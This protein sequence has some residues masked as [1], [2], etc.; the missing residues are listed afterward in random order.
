MHIDSAES[1]LVIITSAVLVI[2][3]LVAIVATIYIVKVAKNI[4]HVV[5][6]AEDVVESAE[7]VTDAFKNVGGPLAAFKLMRN[8]VHVVNKAQRKSY[9][10]K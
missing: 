2:F 9:K 7:A 10:R 6:K 4:R 1:I 5:G 8:I 3:L